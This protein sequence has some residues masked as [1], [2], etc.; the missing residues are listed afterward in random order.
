MDN[1]FVYE[2][3]NKINKKK[4]IGITR[5]IPSYR[6]GNDGINYKSSPHFYS[7]IQKYGWNNFEHNIL[8][9]GLSKEAACSKEIEL[10]KK[11]NTTNK[12][13]GY[14]VMEGGTAPSMPKE[15]REYMSVVMKGNRNG[16]GKACSEEK[17][18]K[19]SEAQ[20]GRTF[21][22][23]HKHKI[24]MARKGKT[25]HPCSEETRK[26]ISDS[27]KKKP[28]ICLNTLEIYPSIQECSRQTGLWATLICKCCKNK[29]ISTGGLKFAYYDEYL[30]CVNA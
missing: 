29:L 25:T 7:A 27:H 16:Y 18:K 2:H 20:K 28:V 21:T 12:E 14:N 23:E 19:I 11:Y 3:V 13:C 22:E 24:S 10:I 17:K 1:Y 26:K 30:K 4:Y 15:I 8:F 9:S 6:W 5:Q